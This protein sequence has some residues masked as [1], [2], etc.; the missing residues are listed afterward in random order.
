[1]N[2]YVV[3]H[4]TCLFAAMMGLS[5]GCGKS[6]PTTSEVRG[7]I[8]T[9]AGAPC[10]GAFLVFHPQE[11]AR[12]NDAKP[13]AIADAEGN[14]VVRTFSETDGAVPG[15]YAVTVVWPEA[16]KEKKMSLSDEGQG[17]VGGGPD[18]LNAAYGDPKTTT[19]K[20]TIAAQAN[21]PLVVTVNA[22]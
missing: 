18:R 10:D 7:T 22:P 5:L 12:V 3:A 2:R 17:G 15:E 14:F 20:V 16:A 13:L 9:Q 11:Q 19:I 8:K 1:M 6:T 21:E 4:L